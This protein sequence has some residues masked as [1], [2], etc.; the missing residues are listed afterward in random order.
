M[1]YAITVVG[2]SVNGILLTDHGIPLILAFICIRI[3]LTM[4][5]KFF[6]LEIVEAKT[7]D[8]LL[9]AGGG[10][11]AR[12][13]ANGAGGGGAGGMVV[14]TSIPLLTGTYAITIGAGGAGTSGNA[15]GAQGS[16]S[17]IV[18]SSG[19]ITAKGGG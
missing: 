4:D 6:P 8:V 2:W 10:A 16:D 7:A 3:L 5:L 9:I 18:H 11:G 1:S 13:S 15:Y 19:T 17:T 14:G 12:Y